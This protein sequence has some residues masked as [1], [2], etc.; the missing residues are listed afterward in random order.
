M[1]ASTV[2]SADATDNAY[3]LLAT[4]LGWT[5]PDLVD[6]LSASERGDYARFDVPKGDG[7]VRKLAEPAPKL[8]AMQRRLLDRW[9]NRAVV[10]PFAHGFVPGRSIATAARVHAPTAKA[11]VSADIR[12]AFPSTRKVRVRRAIE[13]HLGPTLK[14]SFPVA[15]ADVRAAAFDM[16]ATACT[17][18]NALPQGAPTSGMLLNLVCGRLDRLVAMHVLAPWR[19]RLPDL[20]YTRYADDLTFTASR[21]IPQEF[22]EELG[23]VVLRSGYELN[24][25]KLEHY[26]AKCRDLLI[27]GVRIHDGTLALPRQTLKRY[28]AL[29]DHA[30]AHEPDSIPED[31]R[32][33]VFGTLGLLRMIYAACPISLERPL[34]RLLHVHRSWLLRPSQSRLARTQQPRAKSLWVYDLA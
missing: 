13:W 17:F 6:A 19:E 18:E 34:E 16:L 24:R 28:R 23:K 27:C 1:T 33:R 2:H 20:L 4:F 21:P 14:H 5:V 15:D 22:V 11:I 9:L 30:I 12:D 26:E 10:S 31:L 32:L 7:R 3:N 25:R 29:F 8:K